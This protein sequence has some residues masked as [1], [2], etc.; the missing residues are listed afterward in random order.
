MTKKGLFIYSV[1]VIVAILFSINQ[2]EVSSIKD[3]FLL[4]G[5]GT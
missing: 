5:Y 3:V 2:V 1:L 4:V